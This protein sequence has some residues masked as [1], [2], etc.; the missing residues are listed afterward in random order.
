M[1]ISFYVMNLVFCWFVTLL[2]QQTGA[3]Q[4][5]GHAVRVTVGRRAAVFEVALLLL[6]DASWD[7]DACAAVSH[8]GGEFVDV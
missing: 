1:E 2:A 5:F 6:T 7:A 8:A 4:G 3:N